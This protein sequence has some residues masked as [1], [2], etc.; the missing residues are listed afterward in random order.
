MTEDRTGT[1]R[2]LLTQ[3]YMAVMTGVQR[4]TIS[5]IANGMKRDR[6]IDYARG[7]VTILDRSRLE[8]LACECYRGV[9]EH[10]EALRDDRAGE[11]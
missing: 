7:Q 1:P 4:S 5:Q 2:F 3:E 11:R 6:V 9:E 8:A 10:F